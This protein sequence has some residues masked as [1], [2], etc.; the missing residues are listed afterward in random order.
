[1]AD[2]PI[3]TLDHYIHLSADFIAFFNSQID[4]ST[5]SKFNYWK[6]KFPEIPVKVPTFSLVDLCL[7][8]IRKN[9]S[10][11][12]VTTLPLDLQEKIN[13]N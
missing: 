8:K 4:L 13:E 3:V 9:K 6:E 1:M 11:Y 12:D 5:P 7:Y 2:Y 10:I